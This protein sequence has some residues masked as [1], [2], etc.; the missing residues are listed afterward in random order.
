MKGKKYTEEL[1][2]VFK[3]AVDNLDYALLYYEKGFK[4]QPT[5]IIKYKGVKKNGLNSLEQAEKFKSLVD[6]MEDLK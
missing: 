4:E 5:L 3:Y 2:E 1:I 6:A